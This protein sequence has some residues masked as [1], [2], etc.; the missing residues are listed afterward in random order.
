MRTTI[1][2]PEDLLREVQEDCGA[3]TK[4]EAV[5]IALKEYIRQRAVRR[6]IA[7][8]GTIEFDED[9]GRLRRSWDR[10]LPGDSRDG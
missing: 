4:R 2:I 3:A 7:A 9:I 10:E 6:L 5:V 1:D 8:A